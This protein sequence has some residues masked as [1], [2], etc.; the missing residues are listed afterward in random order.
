MMHRVEPPVK[1]DAKARPIQGKTFILGLLGALILLVGIIFWIGMSGGSTHVPLSK[2]GVGFTA[3][4]AG[5]SGDGGAIE[6]TTHDL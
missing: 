5:A 6:K 3:D 1:P 2:P 4:D